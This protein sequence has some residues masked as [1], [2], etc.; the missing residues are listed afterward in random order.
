M[1]SHNGSPNV[2]TYNVHFVKRAV[3]SHWFFPG[4]I[5]YNI[6]TY[7]LCFKKSFSHDELWIR[8]ELVQF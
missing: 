6:D 3:L 4:R 5:L 8:T 2:Y 1:F 7:L